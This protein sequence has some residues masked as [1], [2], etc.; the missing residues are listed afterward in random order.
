M[1]P[2]KGFEKYHITKCGKVWAESV[3]R[4]LIPQSNGTGYFQCKLRDVNGRR[5]A[6][7]VHRLVA[8]H[9]LDNPEELT[10]VNHKDGDKS[11]N[12]IDN[13]EWL[14][15]SDNLKHAYKLGLLRNCF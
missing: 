13:L 3:N 15:H 10:D 2:I 14:S 7:Y 8:M 5:K 9:Y 6:F 11:N 12:G 4:Y 1:I